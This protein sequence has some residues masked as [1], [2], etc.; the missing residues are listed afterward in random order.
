MTLVADKRR[1]F[2]LLANVA[3]NA[4]CIFAIGGRRANHGSNPGWDFVCRCGRWC[5]IVCTIA[6][7]LSWLRQGVWISQGFGSHMH[8]G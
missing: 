2:A 3:R 7:E 4:A 1:A 5:R 6:Y 8:G